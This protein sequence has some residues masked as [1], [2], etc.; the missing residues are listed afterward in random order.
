MVF[1]HI[2]PDT[3]SGSLF[4]LKRGGR[5]V[6]CGSTSGVS[7]ETNLFSIFQ[8]QLHIFGSFGASIRNVADGLDKM[9]RGIKPVIDS[10]FPIADLQMGL[11]RL[12]NRQVFGKVVIHIAS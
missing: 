1:E 9:A 4:A 12:I 2:G 6:T 10:E 8:Q 7:T 11:D 3:W 5:L